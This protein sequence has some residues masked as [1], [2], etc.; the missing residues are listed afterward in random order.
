MVELFYAVSHTTVKWHF[1][2]LRWKQNLSPPC[3]K[4]N[5]D[6][7]T[8][9][10]GNESCQGYKSDLSML[11]IVRNFC[12]FKVLKASVFLSFK[13]LESMGF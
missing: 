4:D 11:A 8:D 5:L 2:V 12:Q 6:T 7:G 13:V 9:V 3:A 10:S 1:K